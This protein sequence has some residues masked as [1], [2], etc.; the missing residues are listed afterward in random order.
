MPFPRSLQMQPFLFPPVRRQERNPILGHEPWILSART[1]CVCVAA[2]HQ[3]AE[4]AAG[5]DVLQLLRRAREVNRAF[6]GGVQHMTAPLD[7]CLYGACE[8]TLIAKH[9][10]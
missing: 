10:N 7:L 8:W 4:T 6:S 5:D 9:G 1:V 2:Q 3:A